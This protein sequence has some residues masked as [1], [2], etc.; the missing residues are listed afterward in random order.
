MFSFVIYALLMAATYCLVRGI[1][2]LRQQR[3]IW[4]AAGLLIGIISIGILFLPIETHAVSIGP[5][6]S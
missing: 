6:N 2:D 4:A 3:Y 1:S 5:L